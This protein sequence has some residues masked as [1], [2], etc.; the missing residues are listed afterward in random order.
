MQWLFLFFYYR[1]I[2]I[3]DNGASRRRT[4]NAR[5][6]ARRADHSTISKRNGYFSN[7][8]TVVC[9]LRSVLLVLEFMFFIVFRQTNNS[10]HSLELKILFTSFL[11]TLLI[12]LSYIKKRI[13]KF[14]AVVYLQEKCLRIMVYNEPSLFRGS[15]I[16]GSMLR[17]IKKK[18]IE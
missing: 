9:K 18:A 13:A 14:S 6:R 11:L 5:F 4:R 1:S 10:S 3:I 15:A 8:C 12:D 7:S 16:L 2:C 17:G